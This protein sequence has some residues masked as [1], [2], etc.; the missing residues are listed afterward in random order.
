MGALPRLVPDDHAAIQRP[1]QDFT[2]R[3]RRPASWPP[4]LRPWRYHALRVQGVADVAERRLDLIGHCLTPVTQTVGYQTVRQGSLHY[5]SRFCL[6]WGCMA[7]DICLHCGTRGTLIEDSSNA[8]RA[9]YFR[10]TCG[11]TWSVE[12]S[13][14]EP[15]VRAVTAATQYAPRCTACDRQTRL[16]PFVSSNASVD[17]FHCDKCGAVLVCDKNSSTVI[18]VAALLCALCSGERWICEKHPSKPWP[19]SDCDSAG[20]PCPVCQDPNDP[21]TPPVEG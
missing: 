17:Y 7:Q 12:G 13:P 2:H 9:D 14:N 16:L 20:A 21:P 11:H 3:G 4:L 1:Q 19:H 8:T 10:C 6:H 15:T 5:H 18:H